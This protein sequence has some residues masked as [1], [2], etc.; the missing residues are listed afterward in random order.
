MASRTSLRTLGGAAAALAAA[1]GV[2]AVVGT[3]VAPGHTASTALADLSSLVH[4]TAG[5]AQNALPGD[6]NG[7]DGSWAPQAPALSGDGA[8]GGGHA[9]SAGS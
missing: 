9:Q 2:G 6:R 1:L 3:V 4:G 7:E 5:D 8:V